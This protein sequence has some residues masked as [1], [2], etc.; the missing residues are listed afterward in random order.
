[1]NGIRTPFASAAGIGRAEPEWAH[2]NEVKSVVGK[3]R[4]HET[5]LRT[6]AAPEDDNGSPKVLSHEVT[7][8]CID[9]LLNDA[10]FDLLIVGAGL[11]GATIA[12]RCS[13]ELNL[14]CLVIDKR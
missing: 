4:L 7:S 1:M 14:Q 8:G 5:M 3:D 11:S 9:D 12:E 13:R 10:S 6:G 2:L